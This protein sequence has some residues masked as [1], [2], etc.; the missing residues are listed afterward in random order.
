MSWRIDWFL[1][2]PDTDIYFPKLVEHLLRE[3]L[4]NKFPVIGLSSTYVEAGALV[5]FDCD[6]E[7]LGKQAAE[8]ALASGMLEGEKQVNTRFV[9]PRKVKLSLNLLTA[10]I[11]GIKVPPEVIEQASPVFGK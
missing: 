6:Y 7:D 8:L 5:S 11:L 4:K 3:S 9:R 10:D 2:I 1:M